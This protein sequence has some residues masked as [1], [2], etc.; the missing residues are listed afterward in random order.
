[1]L[2]G[3]QGL[4]LLLVA[5]EV[6]APTHHIIAVGVS[7]AVAWKQSTAATI[8]DIHAQGGVAIAAHPQGSTASGYDDDALTLLDA[9][10]RTHPG[11]YRT[12]KIE[13]EFAQFFDRGRRFNPR[14]AAVGDSDFH[15]TGRIGLCRTYVLA[16][17][18]SEAG[19]LEALREGRS[20]AYDFYDRPYGDPQLVSV[21][22]TGR[23]AR[24]GQPHAWARP[25][26][27]LGVSMAWVALSALVLLGPDGYTNPTRLTIARA[28]KRSR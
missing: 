20:V 4:P 9:A 28:P 6:T 8:R 11:M 21:V 3:G 26:N 24:T 13:A 2:F 23:R 12:E 10:E 7:S 5:E 27:V 16:R 1:R 15:F 22:E 17:E 19:V 18:V 25:L 14:L